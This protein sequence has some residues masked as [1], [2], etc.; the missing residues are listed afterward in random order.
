MISPRTSAI[1]LTLGLLIVALL[2]CE[3]E[4]SPQFDDDERRQAI[5]AEQAEIEELADQRSNEIAAPIDAARQTVDD[6]TDEAIGA[7]D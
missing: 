4:T 7:V 5:E 6:A 3:D 1:A 2:A